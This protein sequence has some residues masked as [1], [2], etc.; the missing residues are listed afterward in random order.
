[1]KLNIITPVRNEEKYI[2]VTMR[3]MNSQTVLPNKWI[4]VNDGSSDNTERIIR[5]YIDDGPHI[6]YMSLPD[7]GYRKPGQGVIEAFYE[8]Y[9]MI[10]NENYDII[11]KLDADL[12]FPPDTIEKIINAFRDDPLL[13]VTGGTRYEREKYN[14]PYKKVLFPHGFVGGPTK[15]Y[16]KKCFE[17][18][19]GLIRRAGWD[20]V[21][22]I[23]ANMKGWKTCVLEEV[24]VIHLK[25]TGTAVGEGLKKAYE[26]YGDVSYYMGG[27]FWYFFLRAIGRSLE[28]KNP[29]V[30]YYMT[31]GYFRVKLQKAIRES[32]E[33]RKYLKKKQKENVIYFLKLGFSR[34][35]KTR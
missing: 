35:L 9:K 5:R 12:E 13:G 30:G 18:I 3:C 17:D 4:I 10:E 25:P 15:F 7:R 21:D 22:T 23:K 28:K 34:Y 26:K 24:K 32:D 1:M 14:M 27:Y 2:S 31:K 16:R 29:M 6:K 33:F 19:N 20:G 8:G 11:A